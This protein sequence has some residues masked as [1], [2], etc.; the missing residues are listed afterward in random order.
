VR[1]SVQRSLQRL[2]TDVLDVLFIHSDGRDL[3]IMQQTDIVPVLQ[4]LKRQ[5]V[6]RAIGLSGK[7]VEG[8]RAAL[9]WA[10]AL[11][12]MLHADDRSHE[13]VV[14]DAGNRGVG[15][16]VK[17]GLASGHLDAAAAIGYVLGQPAVC[18][19]LV[20]SLSLDHMAANIRA[21]GAARGAL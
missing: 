17:K 7:T 18:S 4:E 1:A 15:V 12:V 14:A 5:G 10:D 8:A 13:Q 11:S 9:D 20:G 19:L 21:A 2:R 16:I 3:W 6:V